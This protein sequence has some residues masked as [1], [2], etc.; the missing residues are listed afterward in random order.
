LLRRSASEGAGALGRG[1]LFGEGGGELFKMMAQVDIVHVPYRGGGPMLTDLIGGH[2]RMAFDNL[3]S[4]I[5][6]IRAGSIRAIA[7]T[8]AERSPSAP[9]IPTMRE[10][11]LPDYEVAAW[12]GLL[13][14]AGTPPEIVAHLQQNVADFL[15]SPEGRKQLTDHGAEPV[16]NTPEEFA[17]VIA[18]EVERWRQVVQATGVKVQ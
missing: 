14:P 9:D 5:G 17:R 18:Y 15:H 8:T 11:G 16:G 1:R 2:I 12:F 10:S 7:V 4:S 6:H 13:A 3:P